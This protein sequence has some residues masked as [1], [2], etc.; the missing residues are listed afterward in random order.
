MR[1]AL[2]LFVLIL[3]APSLASAQTFGL[4]SGT[5]TRLV[6]SRVFG[7]GERPLVAAPTVKQSS[8]VAATHK[9]SSLVQPAT[10]QQIQTVQPQTICIDGRCYPV[11]SALVTRQPLFRRWR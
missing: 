8:T 1:P 3:F 5:E 11:A 9:Q 10:V 6:R 4:G 2:A 7:L